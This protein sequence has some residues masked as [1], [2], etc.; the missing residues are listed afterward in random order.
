MPSDTEHRSNPR[1]P[2]RHNAAAP[3]MFSTNLYTS[4]YHYS[5]ACNKSVLWLSSI[6]SSVS[7]SFSLH[8]I[9]GFI[10]CKYHLNYILYIIYTIQSKVCG[11]L[12]STPIWACWASYSKIMGFNMELVIT[13]SLLRRLSTRV[14]LMT[15]KICAQSVTREIVRLGTDARQ[16]CLVWSC[17]LNSF[18]WGQG[19]H[20][21][22][23]TSLWKPCLCGSC[24][25]HRGTDMLEQVW[26]RPLNSSEGKC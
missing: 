2:T 7:L 14:W 6:T 19:S 20:E 24:F 3:L 16:E 8:L 5:L 26:A 22:F 18:Q 10:T 1:A 23:H 13:A 21:F 25:G 11:H 15:V 9:K 4:T 17:H 12:I